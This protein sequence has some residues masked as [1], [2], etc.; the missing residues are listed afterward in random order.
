MLHVPPGKK[1]L[2]VIVEP[3]HTDDA[4]PIGEGPAFT[5]TTTDAKQPEPLVYL[6]VAVPAETPDTTPAEDIVATGRFVLLHVPL[7]SSLSVVVAPLQS[8]NVPEIGDGSG[9]TTTVVVRTQP[10]GAV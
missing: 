5:V 10:L 8:D 2:N 7:P 6:M 4:P 9:L 1:S 3:T